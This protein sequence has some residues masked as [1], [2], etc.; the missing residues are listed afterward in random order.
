M[1][2]PQLNIKDAETT[3]LVRELVKMTG[4][5]QTQA[6]R[7][8]LRERL[9]REKAERASREARTAEEKRREFETVWAKVKKIQ[10]RVRRRGLSQNMLTDDDLYDE[11]GLPK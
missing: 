10:E 4:E 9:E 11:H 5:T 1:T 6:V 3:Q 7:T 2:T 8:A